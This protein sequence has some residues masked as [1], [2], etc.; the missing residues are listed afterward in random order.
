M[1][2]MIDPPSGGMDACVLRDGSAF[3]EVPGVRAPRR[4]RPWVLGCGLAT[5]RLSKYTRSPSPEM[6]AASPLGQDRGRAG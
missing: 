6:P 5:N 2:G 3:R 4:L 1:Q